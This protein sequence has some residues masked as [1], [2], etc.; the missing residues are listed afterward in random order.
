MFD[1]NTQPQDTADEEVE[2]IF[3]DQLLIE[4]MSEFTTP[5]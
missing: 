4:S 2:E 1:S 5:D 3:L